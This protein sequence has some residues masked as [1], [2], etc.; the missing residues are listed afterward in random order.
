M[1]AAAKRRY[2]FSECFVPVRG[3]NAGTRKIVCQRCVGISG[4]EPKI[5]GNSRLSNA[6]PA[7]QV[8]AIILFLSDLTLLARRW[9][10]RRQLTG[11]ALRIQG[12]I[13]RVV[14]VSHPEQNICVTDCLRCL[15]GEDVA[16]LIEVTEG[17]RSEE[18]TSELQSHSFISYA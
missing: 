17:R 11:S 9:N 12:I 2:W 7:E 3:E 1:I 18:H 16:S 8:D 10:G 13:D 14:L 4:G 5:I 15:E 6:M